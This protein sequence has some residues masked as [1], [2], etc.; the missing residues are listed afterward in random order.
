MPWSLSGAGFGAAASMTAGGLVVV[1]GWA[2]STGAGS[3]AGGVV[4]AAFGAPVTGAGAGAE[5]VSTATTWTSRAADETF[6]PVG[7][8]PGASAVLLFAWASGVGPMFCSQCHTR[9][10]T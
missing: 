1:I 6:C 10:K 2:M 8:R 9:K 5:W 4:A 7:A 3:D